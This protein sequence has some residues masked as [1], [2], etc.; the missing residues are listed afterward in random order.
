M[1]SVYMVSLCV[2][3]HVYGYTRLMLGCHSQL[4][5]NL[6]IETMSFTWT[7]PHWLSWAGWLAS[8]L[9]WTPCFCLWVLGL[10]GP[11]HWADF[12]LLILKIWP[13]N[14]LVLLTC[15]SCKHDIR[16]DTAIRVS[17]SRHKYALWI[18]SSFS[19]F[20]LCPPSFLTA[21]LKLDIDGTQCLCWG[22]HHRISEL[23][24]ICLK[25]RESRSRTILP[26]N[27]EGSRGGWWSF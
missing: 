14:F 10:D 17:H 13:D 25:Q 20:P 1:Y 9:Q 11:P 3:L 15:S 2:C 12:T 23:T 18:L 27:T 24:A 19:T 5:F 26:D 16:Y 6:Y 8:L 4:F 22:I 21:Q 7:K